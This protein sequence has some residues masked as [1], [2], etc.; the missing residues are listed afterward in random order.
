MLVRMP[1]RGI[2]P[3]ATAAALAAALAA[4]PR[5]G[6]G[7][8][9]DPIAA[10]IERWSAFVKGNPATDEIWKQ[11]KDG[12]EAALGRA[13]E[14]LRAGR[15]LLALQRL[16]YAR[17]YLL[18]AAYMNERSAAERKDTAAFEAEWNRMGVVLRD[19]LAAPRA[20]ALAGVQPAALRALGEAALPQARVYYEASLEYGRNTMPDS[21]LFY[22]GSAQAQREFVVF[23]R[24]FA[25]R[26]A[27]RAPAVRALTPELDALDAEMLAVYRPPLSIDKHPQFITASSLL[28]EARELD[29]AGLRYGALLRYLQAAYRFAPLRPAPPALDAGALAA[30]LARAQERL[31]PGGVDHSVGLLFLETA[32]SEAATL[33]GAANAAAIVADVLPRYFRAL[34][35]AT[36]PP[37]APPAK[38]T[39]TL[40]RWPYT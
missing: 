9:P 21:G 13:A 37:P 11:I 40:V 6:F 18:A 8:A 16:A 27:L 30:E 19:E 23:A 17:D 10:E 2:R 33:E 24:R 38:V 32:Q 1:R 7:A 35:P 29:A 20:D 39:V 4:W 25:E 14:A 22:L 3:I 31:K 15:R 36:P 12:S 5:A 26:S 34:E 28:K